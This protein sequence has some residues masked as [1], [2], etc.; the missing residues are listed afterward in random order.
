MVGYAG[1]RMSRVGSG[2]DDWRGRER[3][4]RLSMER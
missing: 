4:G 2:I 1:L 3:G